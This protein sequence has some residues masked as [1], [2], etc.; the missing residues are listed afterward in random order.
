MVSETGDVQSFLVQHP[1][2][3]HLTEKQLEFA[4]NNIYVAFSKSGSKLQL[5]NSAEASYAVGL[6]IVR[7]GSLEIR[8]E[9]NVLLD[10]LS[11]GDDWRVGVGGAT[12]ITSLRT[13]LN[14]LFDPRLANGLG[15][16][17]SEM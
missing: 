6:F 8:S 16:V 14:S 9:Q 17:Q 13:G 10:R 12:Y 11:A 4:S 5:N 7:S 15:S 2:F 1:P 3:N